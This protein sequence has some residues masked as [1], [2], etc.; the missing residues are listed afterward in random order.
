MNLK[1]LVFLIMYWSF[2]GLLFYFGTDV[3]IGY[4][5]SDIQTLDSSLDPAEQD[6]GGLF[7]GGVSFLRFA[8]LVAFGIGLPSVPLF[9]QIIF[10]FWQSAVTILSIGFFIDSIWSG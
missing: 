3:L 7:S 10:S 5:V 4:S 6:T 9:F 2:W 8:G 1:I